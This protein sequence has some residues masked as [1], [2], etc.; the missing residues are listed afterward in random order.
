[1]DRTLEILCF[2]KIHLASII[3]IIGLMSA[4][5][6]PFA[7]GFGFLK[8]DHTT[9][10]QSEMPEKHI[11]AKEKHQEELNKLRLAVKRLEEEQE[12]LMAQCNKYTTLLGKI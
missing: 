5:N 11:D 6:A 4:S 2:R 10:K 7:F 12:L 9:E 3:F 1:M 8:K